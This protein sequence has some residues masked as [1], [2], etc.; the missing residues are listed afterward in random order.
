MVTNGGVGN[1]GVEEQEIQT[2]ERKVG[3]RIYCAT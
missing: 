1:V 3:S 2:T